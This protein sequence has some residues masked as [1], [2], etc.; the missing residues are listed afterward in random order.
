VRS[1]V[2]STGGHSPLVVEVNDGVITVASQ[3]SLAGPD[4]HLAP[5]THFGVLLADPVIDLARDFLFA[6]QWVTAGFQFE[7]AK[8]TASQF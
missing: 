2:V 7:R 3:T 4:Y 6:D 8:Q 1:V 5:S